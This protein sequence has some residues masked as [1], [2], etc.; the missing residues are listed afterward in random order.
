MLS[1]AGAL[2]CEEND[3]LEVNDC[4]SKSL[5]AEESDS[6]VECVVFVLL[7][8]LDVDT[9]LLPDLDCLFSAD[10]SG[11]LCYCG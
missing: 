9:A 6:V 8:D 1:R 7:V 3:T 5:F 2:C 11:A 4:T 10:E